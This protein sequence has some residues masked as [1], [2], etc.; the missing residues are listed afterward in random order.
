VDEIVRLARQMYEELGAEPPHPGG[1]PAWTARATRVLAPRLEVDV[2]VFVVDDPRRTGRIVSCGA[3]TLWSRLPTPWHDDD[4]IGHVQWMSTDPGFRRLGHG[5]S[6]LRALLGWFDS[7]G[8]EVVELN[9]S[10]MGEPLY[11]AEGFDD[12]RWGAP[13]RRRR[14]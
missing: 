12:A 6:I 8:V 10:S 9:A 2:R 4:R 5:R 11:R 7:L 1:W 3:G 13:L 14:S